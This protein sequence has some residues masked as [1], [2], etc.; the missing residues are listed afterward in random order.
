MIRVE[1]NRIR[2]GQIL[3]RSVVNPARPGEILLRAGMTLQ[4]RVI[5][6]LER[7]GVRAFWIRTEGHDALESIFPEERFAP[8]RR[9]VADLHDALQRVES[10][11]IEQLKVEAFRDPILAVD[12]A[13]R[14]GPAEHCL[15]D[16]IRPRRG[17]ILYHGV[18]VCCLALRMYR[19]G[20]VSPL[21]APGA[22]AEGT[23]AGLGLGALFHDIGKLA[24]EERVIAREPWEHSRAEREA[25][26][27]HPAEGFRLLRP[28]VGAIAANMALCHH[29]NADGTGYPEQ[30]EETGSHLPAQSAVHPFSQLVAA[31]N[32]YEELVGYARYQPLKAL[33]ELNCARRHHFRPEALE[34][35]NRVVS[36]FPLGSAVQLTSGHRGM[37][38]GF[39]PERPFR[40]T[41]R[42]LTDSEGGVRDEAGADLDLVEHPQ[43]CIDR[44][45]GQSVAHLLPEDPDTRWE[46]MQ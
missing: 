35:L 10:D 24:L 30:L 13:L 15:L 45:G 37:V 25:Y 31:A 21:E 32:A 1:T 8:V 40:P 6:A 42:L 19:A 3:A 43:F 26:R 33:E 34:A 16:E 5:G 14:Q 36:P 20:I 17:E 44:A 9:L 2:P 38:T 22:E 29:R 18:N 28:R 46:Q 41:V 11:G 4:A 7:F 39:N 12:S 23:V 27:R